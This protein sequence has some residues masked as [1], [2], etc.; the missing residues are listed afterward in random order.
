M[1]MHNNQEAGFGMA[2]W[3]RWVLGLLLAAS[4][5][6]AAQGLPTPNAA[7]IDERR[8]GPTTAMRLDA[9]EHI[10]LDG[11]LDDAAWQ[12]AP[13][14]KQF[15]EI[16]PR[17]GL[18]AKY[19][20]EVRI[21]YDRHALYIGLTALDPAPQKIDAPLAR[22]D[23]IPNAND[24]FS[25]YIDPIGTRK[26]AQ[27]FRV[28]AAGA[29]S[30]GL[31]NEDA[32]NEDLSP[33]FEWDAKTQRTAEGWT[34]EVRIPF[35]TL[36]YSS[37]PSA[38]WSFV[39][40]RA[41]ARDEVY[42]FGNAQMP[43]D[44]N[45][46]LCYGQS[47][48]GMDGL[49]DGHEF[50]LTPQLTWRRSGDNTNGVGS[51]GHNDFVVSADVKYRPRA[52]LVFDATI[53]PDFS[54]VELDTP[55]LAANS[56][57]ALFFPEKRAFFQ[58]GADIL[59]SPFSAIY[60]RS[61][62]NPAWGARL[63]QRNESS[64]FIFLTARDDGGGL[65]LLPGS[66]GTNVALQDSKSQATIGRFRINRGAWTFGGL[67][68]DR[69]YD[70]NGSKPVLYNRVGGADVVWH[71]SEALRVRAQ[72]LLSST[73]DER[74]AALI[75]AG[76]PRNDNATLFDFFYNDPQWN[77]SGDF[78]HAGRGFRADNGFFSQVGYNGSFNYLQH[79]WH[80][81]GPFNTVG[82]QF[83]ANVK[84]DDSGRLLSKQLFP[85]IFLSTARNTG[86]FF[87]L[88]PGEQVRYREDGAPLKVNRVYGNIESN[89]GR[90]LTYFFLEAM[91]GDRG[92]VINNRIGKGYLL[93]TTATLRLTDRWEL[94]PRLDN[95]V[96]DA[97]EPVAG[98]RRVLLERAVQL[99]S[100]YHFSPR[101]TLRFIG[102]YNG[103][104][105][106]PSLYTV[107]VSAFQKNEI[108]SMVYG[109]RRGLGTNFYLGFTSS[110]AL[111]PDGNYTRRQNE[112]FAKWSWA[113]DL[114]GIR[115][116]DGSD[117]DGRERDRHGDEAPQQ[118]RVG[119]G[120]LLSSGNS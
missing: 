50:T 93:S 47:L 116:T 120:G 12:R 66:L 43:R 83:K 4:C 111:D 13:V 101:D 84:Y 63:T 55:Q 46:F 45:C 119:F 15:Y 61:I 6:A 3:R 103:V 34:A 67:A 112:V 52:D 20:T 113:F 90:M 44:N 40:V 41:M 71:P 107:P 68:T 26:F 5:V 75:A 114:N 27:L 64:D 11:Q 28:N 70:T 87:E 32:N 91:V 110:R 96:I 56:Q 19:P 117:R 97:K 65:I 36:R 104:R 100:I 85:G 33:D 48:L 82:P 39:I 16:S 74:N 17:D 98:S 62:N 69:S 59:S 29:V 54:Q 53:N 8:I 118:R 105:R 92:D 95:S 72:A 23:Q 106:A 42:R 108:A 18:S 30:D 89:P 2:A 81:I 25:I 58:E 21:V 9:A 73:R 10:R 14:V 60:T 78:E 1:N 7:G 102:Q 38:N 24:F 37:P 57:F 51:A 99:K 35:A 80:D 31:Y 77:F 22:R 115:D 86:L 94:E 76:T 79:K 49:P 88:R 109:H